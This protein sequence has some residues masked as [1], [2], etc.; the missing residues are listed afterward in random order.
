MP[1]PLPGIG[2]AAGAIGASVPPET[3]TFPAP[4]SQSFDHSNT[5]GNVT[6]SCSFTNAGEVTGHVSDVPGT[7][8]GD[9]ISPKNSFSDYEIKAHKES[10][11]T[12]TGTVDAWLS[13]GT[14]RTWSVTDTTVGMAL[15]IATVSFQIRRS[16]SI[17]PAGT[18]LWQSTGSH[19]GMTAERT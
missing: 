1:G 19:Y 12:V 14:T 17:D 2:A 18:I 5:G 9:W 13:L 11:S 10:G 3:H 15:A 7:D 8:V 4:V 6:C 16:L